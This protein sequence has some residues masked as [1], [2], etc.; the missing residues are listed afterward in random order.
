[1]Y[2]NYPNPFNPTTTIKYSI[3]TYNIDANVASSFSLSAELK[4]YDI[5]GKEVTTLVS[6]NK[7]P[8]EYEVVFDGSNLAS[9]TYIYTMRMGNNS[10]SKKMLLL[11]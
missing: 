10:V 3:P 2:Q 9:G 4:I 8:G 11:K 7:S 6:E 5:L 1:L